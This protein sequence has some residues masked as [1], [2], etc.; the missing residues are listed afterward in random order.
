MNRQLL[1][2][3]RPVGDIKYSDFKLVERETPVPADGEVLIKTL[4]LAVEP[5]MRGWM[6]NRADYVAPLELGDLM[7]GYGTGEVIASNNSQFAV[8]SR[9]S[10]SFGW[11]EFLVSDGK[12]VPLQKIAED[13]DLPAAMGLLGVTGLTAYFGL[14]EIGQ[15]QPGNTV[16][17]SGAAGATGSVVVQLAKIAGCRVI[18]MAGTSEKCDWVTEELG[19]DAAIN[20]REQDVKAEVRRLCPD[21]INVYYDN[22][23]GEIL[24]IALANLAQNARVVICGGISRYNLTGEIP[25]PKNYFNLVF[26]RS[27][28]EGFIVGDYASRFPEAIEELSTHLREGKLK[29]HE[30]ILDGFEKMP[31]ALMGLFSGSN[32]GK[33]LVR[34]SAE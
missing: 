22:V 31:D 8:G 19:A 14:K 25:G 16:L 26:R 20:Y 6:E 29:H 32:M 24:D 15:P 23:G 3:A 17:V 10:G 28:M 13:I 27:R 7:R 21:G 18:G 1:L 11:Q 2:N 9:V 5:A 34:V 33:Q 4:Y 30:T 12:S